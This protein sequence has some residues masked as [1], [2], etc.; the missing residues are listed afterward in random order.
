MFKYWLSAAEEEEKV[1]GSIPGFWGFSDRFTVLSCRSGDLSQSV[2][3]PQGHFQRS[4]VPA[5]DFAHGA[6]I[7][8][9]LHFYMLCH[10][11]YRQH[12]VCHPLLSILNVCKLEL[13]L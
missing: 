5:M 13:C 4:T 2:T 6:P 3:T 1:P 8:C 7:K 11:Q 12:L 9:S 10:F